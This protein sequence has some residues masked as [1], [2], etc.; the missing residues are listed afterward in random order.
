MHIIYIQVAHFNTL[1]LFLL[2][3]FGDKVTQSANTIHR[4]YLKLESEN[5][6]V[7]KADIALDDK[8]F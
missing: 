6:D 2:I 1:L 3:G 5:F 8:N 4:L 7:V